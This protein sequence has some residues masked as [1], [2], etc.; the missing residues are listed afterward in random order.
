LPEQDFVV[1]LV[2]SELGHHALALSRA[3]AQAQSIQV[4][5]PEGGFFSKAVREALPRDGDPA[6][7]SLED[8]N[9]SR[10]LGI[11]KKTSKKPQERL[12]EILAQLWTSILKPVIDVL[13]LKVCSGQLSVLHAEIVIRKPQE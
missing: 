3:G 5:P 4:V 13:K 11:S 12:D 8:V 2:T 10:M 9:V 7:T 1:I 6:L